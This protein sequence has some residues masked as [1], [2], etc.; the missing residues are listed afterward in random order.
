MPEAP[1]V[2][3][4]AADQGS[5]GT[6]T[7]TIVAKLE[8]EEKR[9]QAEV[10]ANRKAT[11]LAAEAKKKQEAEVVEDGL[12]LD[13]DFIKRTDE[14]FTFSDPNNPEGTVYKGKDLKELLQNIAHGNTEKDKY[15][16]QLKSAKT[17]E[18]NKADEAVEEEVVEEDEAVE[19][20]DENKIIAETAKRHGFDL[21][22][23]TWSDE[24]WHEVELESGGRYVRKLEDQMKQVH[25]EAN[26]RLAQG[27]TV[28]LNE[29]NLTQETKTVRRLLEDA[30]IDKKTFPY[31]QILERVHKSKDNFDQFG[32]RIQG[33]IVAEATKE[34]LK[35]VRA[36]KAEE[37]A[38]AKSEKAIKARL[39]KENLKGGGSASAAAGTKVNEKPPKDTG[40]AAERALRLLNAG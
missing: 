39:I 31:K 3:P 14:G 7:A 12:D 33:V 27:N 40:E 28:A 22:I 26:I 15:I 11:D 9:A 37:D 4:K 6:D 8:A 2:V 20:P 25:E 38:G 13:P 29:L 19:F 17:A 16:N 34:V 10:E 1:V 21:E 30:G 18:D 36:Q 24:K 5:Q 23:L 32:R 35:I